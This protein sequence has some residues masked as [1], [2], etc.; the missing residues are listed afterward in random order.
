M[1]PY[2]DIF[3]KWF[4]ERADDPPLEPMEVAEE[5]C[6]E[7]NGEGT[8]AHSAYL[9]NWTE[10]CPVCQGEGTIKM[11]IAHDDIDYGTEEDS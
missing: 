4:D 6:N 7:C 10:I 11:Y 2:D 9:S 5:V 3:E 8:I 1:L